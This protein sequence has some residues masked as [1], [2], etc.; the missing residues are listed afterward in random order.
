[1]CPDASPF[2]LWF[3][4]THTHTHTPTHTHTGENT[5][6]ETCCRSKTLKMAM[7][8]QAWHVGIV[9]T[10]QNHNFWSSAM[11]MAISLQKWGPVRVMVSSQDGLWE[12]LI[13]A[14]CQPGSGRLCPQGQS[15]LCGK[16]R[17]GGL[18]NHKQNSQSHPP[19]VRA[20]PFHGPKYVSLN[21][22]L[23]HGFGCVCVY[24]V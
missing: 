7:A 6:L 18:V 3:G 5:Q 10:C 24:F 22:L 19:N 16:N 13:F 17:N 23:N 9:L 11:N 4:K 20:T 15:C 1:M 2:F 8:S 14:P 12:G 21:P